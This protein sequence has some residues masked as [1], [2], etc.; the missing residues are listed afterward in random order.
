MQPTVIVHLFLQPQVQTL[1]IPCAGQ[2]VNAVAGIVDIQVQCSQAQADAK[3][4]GQNFVEERLNQNAD[5]ADDNEFPNH[6]HAP[7]GQTLDVDQAPEGPDNTADQCIA[8]KQVE[9][10][11][12]HI[13]TLLVD[14]KD[15]SG[16][17]VSQNQQGQESY[18]SDHPRHNV[19][20]TKVII[21]AQGKDIAEEGGRNC[22][23]QEIEY[24]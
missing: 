4:G 12:F 21:L 18:G 13:E 24:G 17:H 9:Q 16:K 22:N 8:V 10:G 7:E 3:A 11:T 1:L 6:D 20:Q 15:D 19:P 23:L 14:G 5:C 2:S